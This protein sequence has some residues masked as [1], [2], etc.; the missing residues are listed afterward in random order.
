[1]ELDDLKAVWTRQT[2]LLESSQ[3]LNH[4]LVREQNLERTIPLMKRLGRELM[5]ELSLVFVVVIALGSFAADYR[6]EPGL[7]LS[8]ALV[9]LYAL[10]IAQGEIR[11]VV[12]LRDLN[13]DESVV[14]LAQ[15]LERLRVVRI[16]TTKLALLFAPIMWVPIGA[17]L[18]RVLLGVDLYVLLSPTYIIANI[19]FGLAIIPTAV[20]VANRWSDRLGRSRL[21]RAIG[22]EITGTNLREALAFLDTLKRF[23]ESV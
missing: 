13:F 22:R 2:A 21:M 23:E 4:L 5:W 16:R 7:A 15:K 19:V 9:G 1:M 11:Q 17:V 14:T 3:R 18:G 8:A 6:I 12:A 20:F 10:A